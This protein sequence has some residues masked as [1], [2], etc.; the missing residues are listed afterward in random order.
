M[1]ELQEIWYGDDG[2]DDGDGDGGLKTAQSPMVE[3][4]HSAV[5]H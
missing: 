2:G 3:T 4:L 1:L 5:Y